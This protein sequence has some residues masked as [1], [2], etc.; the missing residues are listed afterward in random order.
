MKR[1]LI[2]GLGVSIVTCAAAVAAPQ[3]AAQ[4][5]KKGKTV[6]ITGC[7]AAGP[8]AKIFVLNDALPEAAAKAEPSAVAGKST[9]MKSYQVMLGEPTLKL[10]DHVGHKVTLTGTVEDKMADAGAPAPGAPTPGAPPPAATGTAGTAGAGK[11]ANFT[12]TGIKHV[13]TSCTQ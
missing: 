1:S 13:A 12:V 8:D 3:D 11:L 6:T 10:T 7:L 4:D 5:A 2:L 9:E